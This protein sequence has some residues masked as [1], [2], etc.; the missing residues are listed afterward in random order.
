[1]KLTRRAAIK[2]EA[3]CREHRDRREGPRGIDRLLFLVTRRALMWKEVSR[4]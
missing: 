2:Q 4:H 1:M 3:D